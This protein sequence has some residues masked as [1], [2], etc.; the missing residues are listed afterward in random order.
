M[1]HGGAISFDFVVFFNRMISAASAVM[2]FCTLFSIGATDAFYALFLLSVKIEA[3]CADHCGNYENDDYVCKMFHYFLS[4][5]TR[6][7]FFAIS[8]A[9]K[10]A[11][12]ATAT[13]PP[14][15]PP[16]LSAEGAVM[17]VPIVLT[18]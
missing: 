15:T 16:I 12:A 10:A 9:R 8:A 3:Y 18:R 2:H 4:E 17:R 5:A 7:L 1:P 13:A 11:N 14:I 6:L